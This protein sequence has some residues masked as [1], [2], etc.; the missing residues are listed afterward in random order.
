M[1]AIYDDVRVL[2]E[3][4][5]QFRINDWNLD[6]KYVSW[7]LFLE[8]LPFIFL[9][10]LFAF[11]LIPNILVI[12]APKFV[13]TKVKDSMMHS[14][15]NFIISLLFTIP[16]SYLILFALSWAVTKSFVFAAIYL[17]SL[18]SLA[19]FVW[20]YHK[21]WR[22]WT[23]LYRFHFLSKSGKISDLV[24]LRNRTHDTL[25]DLLEIE[26][27]PLIRNLYVRFLQPILCA[28]RS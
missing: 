26:K 20:L 2:E 10:P 22:K 18:P 8:S 13:N 7:K 19:I 25:N 27:K 15:I 24:V 3:K 1:Q 4:T 5:K 17:F 28:K 6:R 21:A 16:V 23:S 14:A 9:F 11:S 12:Y